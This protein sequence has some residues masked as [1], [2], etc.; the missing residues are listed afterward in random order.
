MTDDPLDR[1]IRAAVDRVPVPRE[2][3][4]R[5]RRKVVRRRALWLAA[6]AALM[7]GALS[8]PLVRPAPPEP[9]V[10]FVVHLSEPTAPSMTLPEASIGTRAWASEDALWVRFEG[11]RHD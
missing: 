6:A 1:A 8:L 2:L 5:I 10:D 7:L 4:R 9:R 11:T 3:E